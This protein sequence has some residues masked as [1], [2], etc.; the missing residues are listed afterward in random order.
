MS[1]K[2]GI[3]AQAEDG[4]NRPRFA[5]PVAG[6]RSGYKNALYR[7]LPHPLQRQ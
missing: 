5:L 6:L 1:A 2:I 4:D 3:V 7:G